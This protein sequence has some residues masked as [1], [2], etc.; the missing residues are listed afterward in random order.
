MHKANRGI[1]F[2]AG[3]QVEVLRKSAGGLVFDLPIKQT[4]ADTLL[5]PHQLLRRYLLRQT[6][7]ISSEHSASPR[8]VM[9]EPGPLFAVDSFHIHYYIRL[10]QHRLIILML[11]KIDH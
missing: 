7:S 6:P 10:L 5:G 2:H 11:S 1:H 4:S 3:F 9:E 8:E